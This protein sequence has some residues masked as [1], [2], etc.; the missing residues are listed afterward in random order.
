ML[1]V[2][3]VAS[4]RS[5]A[6]DATGAR[7]ARPARARPATTRGAA[8]PARAG[9]C[10]PPWPLQQVGPAYLA[11]QQQR[12]Q[13]RQ[14]QR[15]GI[16]RQGR[17]GESGLLGDRFE[18]VEGLADLLQL[19][20]I[21][22]AEVFAAGDVADGAQAGF[23]QVQRAETEAAE[24]AALPRIS[25]DTDGVDTYAFV[26]GQLCGNQRIDLAA[27]VRPVGDQ[28]QYAA[29]GRTLTQAL[30]RQADCIADGGVLAGDADQRLVQP[31]AHRVAVEGQRRLQVGLTAEQDQADA[32]TMAAFDEIAEQALDQFQTADWL[33]IP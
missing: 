14:R 23:V 2:T 16:E 32:I 26:G 12:A 8:I 15:P 27:V 28:H 7:A 3:A 29:L 21:A 10:P 18:A 30:D 19:G 22:C 11:D 6:R 31:G 1:P 13:Q 33:V 17:A 24:R 5:G 20:L 9:S 25:A 4:A